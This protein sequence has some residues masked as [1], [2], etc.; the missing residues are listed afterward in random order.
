M[1]CGVRFAKLFLDLPPSFAA[2][3][4][5][6]MNILQKLIA[7]HMY[8]HKVDYKTK[9]KLSE[10]LKISIQHQRTIEAY[11]TTKSH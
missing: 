1:L 4:R 2:C 11:A 3:I 7:N 10:L 6:A 8:M 9:Q 5:R